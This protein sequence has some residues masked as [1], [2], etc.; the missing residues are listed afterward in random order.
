MR[1]SLIF[2]LMGAFLL[3]IAIGSLVIAVLT[4]Q[5][6]RN[7]FN[8]YTTRSDQ[9]W[10]QR[11]APDL[12]DYYAQADN[13]NGVDAVLQSEL[14]TQAIPVGMGMGQGRGF[15]QG[16]QNAN[17]GM[18]AGMEQRLILADEKVL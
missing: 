6:T 10:A 14:G 7:A 12:A 16:Q 4:S 13:W 11:L 2:K 1:N 17:N 8:L 9:V 5:A 18:M 3:V 15:G